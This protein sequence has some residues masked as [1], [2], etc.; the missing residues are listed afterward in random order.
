MIA[1]V[2]LELAMGPSSPR[3]PLVL[4]IFRKVDPDSRR[5]SRPAR[6]KATEIPGLHAGET[7]NPP[8]M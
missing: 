3:P 2:A 7:N 5:L 4:L 6:K 1:Q 8:I